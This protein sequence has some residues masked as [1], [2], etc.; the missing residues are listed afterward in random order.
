MSLSIWTN[1]Y[2]EIKS[3]H[4]IPCSLR[5]ISKVLLAWSI[6]VHSV[7]EHL[8][9]ALNKQRSS[10]GFCLLPRLVK[11][12]MVQQIIVIIFWNI[13]RS[14]CFLGIFFFLHFIPFYVYP[15][16]KSDYFPKENR[17]ELSQDRVNFLAV[18]GRNKFLRAFTSLSPASGYHGIDIIFGWI[19]FSI[20]V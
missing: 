14:L 5:L 11:W 15:C 17:K 12:C 16:P 13:M 7:H 20:Y 3:N 10:T 8:S 19:R 9:W 2:R 18:A 6:F 4:S 1:Y